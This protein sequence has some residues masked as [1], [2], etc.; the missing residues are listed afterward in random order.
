MSVT[1]PRGFRAAGATGGS[2]PSG[3]PDLGL[4]VRGPGRSRA[5]GCDLSYE[6][7]RIDGEYTT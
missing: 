1:F 2:K 6:Y 3:L 7:V 5:M 4:L